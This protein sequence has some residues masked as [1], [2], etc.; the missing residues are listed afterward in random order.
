[1]SSNSPEGVNLIRNGN[2]DEFR[3]SLEIEEPTQIILEK[4]TFSD[5]IFQ[6]IYRDCNK[7]SYIEMK[8][9][10]SSGN[11][12]YFRFYIRSFDMKGANNLTNQ[13][14]YGCSFMMADRLDLGEFLHE[15]CPEVNF[16]SRM[17][18]RFSNGELCFNRKD[19]FKVR[20]GEIAFRNF[21]CKIDCEFTINFI[22]RSE[23]RFVP[24]YKQELYLSDSNVE[25]LYG[26]LEERKLREYLNSGK[27][28]RLYNMKESYMFPY[29]NKDKMIIEF[30][31]TNFR[32]I[33]SYYHYDNNDI[34]MRFTE[35]EFR[36]FM[37]LEI[38]LFRYREWMEKN[39]SIIYDMDGNKIMKLKESDIYNEYL[40]FIK[41]KHID[42]DQD[43]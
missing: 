37:K 43:L 34:Q 22:F 27:T 13:L 16:N 31:N 11:I 12:L 29:D 33:D 15:K 42:S 36:R 3:F 30:M 8:L 39:V 18:S 32:N 10:T 35:G 2:Y 41:N 21:P 38:E 5:E 9:H 4:F 26:N 6:A 17:Y 20:N 40:E 19:N 25:V 24:I 7:N 14:I 23:D 1:M 28:F